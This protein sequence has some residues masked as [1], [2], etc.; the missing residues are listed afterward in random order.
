MSTFDIG[1]DAGLSFSRGFLDVM[2]AIFGFMLPFLVFLIVMFG[3]LAFGF[4]VYDLVES[5]KKGKQQ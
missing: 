5:R 3:M 4:F 1:L 2:L